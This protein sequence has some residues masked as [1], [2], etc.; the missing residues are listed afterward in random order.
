[1][2]QPVFELL[3]AGNLQAL[4]TLNSVLFPVKFHVRRGG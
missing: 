4:R 3:T 2:A 1:M